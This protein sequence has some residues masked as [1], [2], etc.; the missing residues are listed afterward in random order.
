MSVRGLIGLTDHVLG[1]KS[2][3]LTICMSIPLSACQFDL[4]SLQPRLDV[5]RRVEGGWVSNSPLDFKQ[6]SFIH[7][8][9]VSEARL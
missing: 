2:L 1:R 5:N 9:Q 6:F 4:D 8:I 7:V 3:E